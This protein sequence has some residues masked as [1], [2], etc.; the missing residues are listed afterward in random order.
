MRTSL[1]ETLARI[2]T[3]AGILVSGCAGQNASS[4]I[5]DKLTSLRGFQIYNAT[6]YTG[7]TSLAL[8]T[9][10]ISLFTS[11]QTESSDI[12][13]LGPDETFGITV[14]LGW[15]YHRTKTDFSAVYRGGYEGMAHHSGVNAFNHSAQFAVSRRLSRKLSVN[16]SGE[17]TE[18]T[19]AQ[20]LFQPARISTVTT[21]PTSFDDFAASL[22]LG[23]FSNSQ[24]ASILTGAPVLESP[25]R[26]L[27][28]GDRVLS[29]SEELSVTYAY[30]PRLTVNASAFSAAGQSRISGGADA[31]LNDHIM[32]RS[33]GGNAGFGFSYLL[34]RRTEIGF[35][36]GEYLIRNAYQHGHGT[37]AY[38]SI[39][40][41][42]GRQWFARVYA[43][44][45][46]MQM[47]YLREG[48]PR[49]RQFVGGGTL[50]IKTFSHRLAGSYDRASSDGF[51][52]A[53]GT[54]TTTMA[55]WGW[56]TP[57]A[58]WGVFST[59]AE[60]Q[61]RNTGFIS[62]SGWRSTGGVSMRIEGQTGMTLEYAHGHNAGRFTG[63][64][65]TEF[66]VDS[67]RLSFNW[68]PRSD[69]VH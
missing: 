66:T 1:G 30:S 62:I 22:S 18:N 21:V 64:N 50:G 47:T 15:Q 41:K 49:T 36:A 51:G 19:L 8:P 61:L 68:T 59:F 32:P 52:F 13:A 48:T 56:Q 42:M 23:Q 12:G 26:S 67:V 16:F 11:P 27:L 58:R 53:V 46:A 14:A 7:Y 6:A 31:H 45:S 43:G 5:Y 55:S 54:T 34:S 4:N 38:A 39:G 65:L 29:N 10:G 63:G 35:N 33:L 69:F 20:F 57:G 25:A 28:L 3:T 2:F 37:N 60:E 44:G 17:M 9:T 40:R 24:L